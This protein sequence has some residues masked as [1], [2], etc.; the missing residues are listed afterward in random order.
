MHGFIHKQVMTLFFR[1]QKTKYLSFIRDDLVKTPF[2]YAYYIRSNY[3]S[4]HQFYC[5]LC[6]TYSD[7]SLFKPLK[8]P[9]CSSV[10]F[11][12]FNSLLKKTG[13]IS[14]ARFWLKIMLYVQKRSCSWRL[15]HNWSI[16]L[17]TKT[18]NF[19]NTNTFTNPMD[20]H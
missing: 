14:S 11:P 10:I 17:D 15:E 1:F 12:P 7:F 3:R 4:C 8:I 6:Y 13:R 16:T 19:F 5:V 20:L 18:P 2:N 9:G